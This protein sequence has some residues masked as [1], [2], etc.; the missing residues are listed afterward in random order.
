MLIFYN[1]LVFHP[2]QAIFYPSKL[3]QNV[4]YIIAVAQEKV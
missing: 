1:H 2:F 4:S 3:L